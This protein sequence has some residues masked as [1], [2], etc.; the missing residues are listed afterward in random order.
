[1]GILL[2][3]T[4]WAQDAFVARWEALRDAQPAGVDLRI[5]SPEAKF[6][7]GEA[8]PLSLS[9]TAT[10][11][12]TFVADSRLQDRVGRMNYIEEFIVDPVAATEDPL[13][14]LPG[15][16]GG[17]GGLSGGNAILTSDKPFTVERTLNEWMR[18]RVPGT[19]RLYVPSRRARQ[20]TGTGQ[21]DQEL[22]M[23]AA[24]RSVEVASNVLTLEI[25][26]AP[27]EWVSE[28]IAAATAVLDAPAGNDSESGRARQRAG[29]TLRFLNTVE[30]GTALAK[31]L[32]E[33][34]SV[35]AFA[36]HSGI[37]DSTHR[38]ELLPVLEQLLVASE[39]AISARF[40][41]TLAQVAALVESGGVMPPYPDDETARQAWQT[42]LQRRAALIAEQR[43]RFVSILLRSLADKEP[44]ART[45]TR[46][47]LLSVAEASGNRPPWLNDIVESLLADFPA[48]PARMQSSLLDSR[49]RLLRDRDI[50][51]LLN[52]LYENPPRPPL[53][54][55][56]IDELVLK[57]IYEL[58]PERGRQLIL[59]E[60]RQKDGP[61]I[62]GN[63]LMMLPD[64]NLPELDEVF[65][66]QVASGRPLP[67]QL[68][69]RYATGEIVKQVEAGYLAFDA[70]LDRQKLPHC[71]FPL[72]FYFLKFD[73][74]FG[75][76]EL[77]KAFAAGRCYD[78][79]RA[80]ESLGPYAMSPALE[81]L[82]IEHLMSPIV[83][84]KR[85]AAEVLG[86]YG[87]RAAEKPLWETMEYFR[88]WW[89]D[90]E[91]DLRKPVG[92]EGIFLERALLT[93]L[94]QA[95]AWVLGEPELRRLLA[96]CSS[97]ECRG[98]VEEW[99]RDAQS[100]KPVEIVLFFN[101]V[102]IKV[103]QYTMTGE[104]GLPAKLAQFPAGTAFRIAQAPYEETR[105][106]RQ[107]VEAA[108]RAARHSIVQ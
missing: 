83:P 4:V 91:D 35:D 38:A 46:D 102:R 57:R 8:I 84:I 73:P 32:P 47:A 108:I 68:I 89:K 106:V 92:Q 39:Q 98:A 76:Q 26:A 87:S 41:S 80:F 85:G 11:P 10:Q 17:M 13:R 37:L 99:L 9:F 90:R 62:G 96:L 94:A 81:R 3:P 100:P 64:V 101:E 55:P 16:S 28:Q 21:T 82:A 23:S 97:G 18:F 59:E 77:R 51:P 6:Y 78:M 29:L 72:V 15:E 58:D 27:P 24:S 14:G 70:E 20:V 52:A 61:R 48:L 74:E 19:Y 65:A 56:S 44:A 49:W 7:L 54:Y 33:A 71:P 60:L 22:R 53:G 67:V 40:L 103:A 104:S 105:Q 63:T 43:D 34:N 2:V 79:G 93:A 25:V 50:L 30:S 95:G 75:E 42:E 86:K 5:T 1:M 31:R 88:S 12:G 66:A 69:A 107:R 36:L 45:L